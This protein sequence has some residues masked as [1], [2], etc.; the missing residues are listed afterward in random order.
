MLLSESPFLDCYLLFLATSYICFNFHTRAHGNINYYNKINFYLASL[1]SSAF[2][3][4]AIHIECFCW[5]NSEIYGLFACNVCTD[6]S[7]LL[8][9][10]CLLHV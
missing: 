7:S 8:S 9:Y 6:S 10:L 2:F 4:V 5:D 3:S 1:L